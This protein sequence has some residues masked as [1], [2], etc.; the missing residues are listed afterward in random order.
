[1]ICKEMGDNIFLFSFSQVDGRRRALEE[2][3]WS[4]GHGHDLLVMLEYDARKAVENLTFTQIP[5]W[6]RVNKL[7]MGMMLREAER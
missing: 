6:A 2:G 3:P 1:M 5:I 4:V 7:P